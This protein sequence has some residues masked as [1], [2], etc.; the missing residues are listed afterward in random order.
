MED[1]ASLSALLRPG[2]RRED[3]PEILKLYE[4]IRRDRAHKVQDLTRIAGRDLDETTHEK[5]NSE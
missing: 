5:F 2:T 1:A 3:I 4:N